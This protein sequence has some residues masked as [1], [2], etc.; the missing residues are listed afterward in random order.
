MYVYISNH[1]LRNEQNPY[2]TTYQTNLTRLGETSKKVGTFSATH[3]TARDTPKD[4]KPLESP[5][6]RQKL[7]TKSNSASDSTGKSI[8]K[9]THSA[10]I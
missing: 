6:T 9:P 4:L 5:I 7:K 1:N 10:V 8:R 2:P 3:F